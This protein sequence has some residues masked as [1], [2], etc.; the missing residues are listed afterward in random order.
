MVEFEEYIKLLAGLLSVV[1]PI[2]AI[3]LFISLTE[4]RSSAERQR[5]ACVCAMSVGAVLLVALVGG[6]F[7]LEFFGISIP[8]FQI[9]GGIVVL[10]MGVSMVKASHDRSRNTPEER[11]ESVDKDS[12]A[13][14]PMAI[15]LLSGPGA[16]STVIVYHNLNPSWNYDVLA[17]CV[18]VT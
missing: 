5:V 12:I 13:V 10:L 9:A 2:A 8:S 17:A 11:A 4:H 15:P 7:L 18:I 16:M 14:V 1:D 6:K 3:P